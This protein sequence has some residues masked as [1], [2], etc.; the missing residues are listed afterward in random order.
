MEKS[1]SINALMRVVQG[2]AHCDFRTA[3]SRYAT[4]D[5][6]WI[7]TVGETGW[8]RHLVVDAIVNHGQDAYLALL[9]STENDKSPA[10]IDH[11]QVEKTFMLSNLVADRYTGI[12]Q[13]LGVEDR[14]VFGTVVGVAR[15]SNMIEF[16]TAVKAAA[17]D[18][19]LLLQQEK[20]NSTFRG[21]YKACL[22]REL[23]IDGN[24]ANVNKLEII[25][26]V[27]TIAFDKPDPLEVDLLL[28]AA[29]AE[30]TG[31]G[32]RADKF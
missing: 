6:P 31:M 11:T 16:S 21:A 25:E 24:I 18:A 20:V 9:K 30:Y 7:I 4:G 23:V 14:S 32:T 1:F 28:N 5:G 3:I 17:T 19:R 10:H 2:I 26:A 15:Y 13:M 8:Q 12:K 29:W 22:D 27:Q